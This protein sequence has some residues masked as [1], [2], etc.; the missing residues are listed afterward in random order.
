M[1]KFFTK[2]IEDVKTIGLLLFL[3]VLIPILCICGFFTKDDD[4]DMWDDPYY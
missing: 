2:L 3:V 1:K 4:V